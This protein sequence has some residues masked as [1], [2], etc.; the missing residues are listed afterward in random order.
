YR[1]GILFTVLIILLGGCQMDKDETST[2]PSEIDKEDLPDVH[3]FEDEFTRKF[4]QSTEE[5]EEGFYP[6]LSKTKKYKMDFPSS[7]VIG[8]RSYSNKKNEYEEFPI[9]IKEGTG[10]KIHINYYSNRRAEQLTADLNRFKKRQGYEG[11]FNKLEKDNQTLYYTNSEG[12]GFR[13]YLGYVQNEK[14][15]GGIELVYEIDCRDE[16]KEICKKNKQNDKKHAMK[17]MKSV[18]FINDDG[19]E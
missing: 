7:G 1:I 5:T 17:W 10:V 9:H 11:D 12:S 3:A 6:F 14:G 8:D 13:D 16:K 2:N 19:Q 15:T 18:Q 4:L